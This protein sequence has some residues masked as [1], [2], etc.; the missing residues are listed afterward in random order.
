MSSSHLLSSFHLLLCYLIISI[1]SYFSFHLAYFQLLLLVSSCLLS[2]LL[3]L[4]SHFL[5]SRFFSFL[6]CI[7]SCLSSSLHLASL[8]L[9][10]FFLFSSHLLSPSKQVMFLLQIIMSL[11]SQSLW[12]LKS[13]KLPLSPDC[14]LHNPTLSALL[15]LGSIWPLFI[16]VHPLVWL[17]LSLS[18]SL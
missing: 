14:P 5:F 6:N 15:F 1:L 16:S 13:V 17:H 11:V 9:S 12:T 18:L 7:P 10:L 4:S 2:A 3:L 8:L